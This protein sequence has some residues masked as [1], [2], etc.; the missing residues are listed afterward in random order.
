[1]PDYPEREKFAI[2]SSGDPEAD[3]RH[4]EQ[5][6]RSERRRAEGICPNGC[7]P[8]VYPAPDH[9]HC[10]KCKYDGYGR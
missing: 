4:L 5:A 10:P 6:H 9:Q 3:Q 1:M 2:A 8:M 7:G